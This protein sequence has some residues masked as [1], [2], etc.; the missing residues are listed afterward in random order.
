MTDWK[1]PQLDC[2]KA[3][4]TYTCDLCDF[5]IH[6]GETYVRIVDIDM[7]K[8]VTARYCE[9]CGNGLYYYDYKQELDEGD[10]LPDASELHQF[11]SEMFLSRDAKFEESRELLLEC[12]T[13]LHKKLGWEEARNGFDSR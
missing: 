6:P 4:K 5:T 3:R 12:M 9:P 10:F 2:P 7:G 1:F 8:F 13:R 11:L